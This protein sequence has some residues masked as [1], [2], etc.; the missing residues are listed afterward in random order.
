M[1]KNSVWSRFLILLLGVVCGSFSVIF[2]RLATVPSMVLVAYRMCFASLFLVP[3]IAA[4]RGEYRKLSR[5][6]F[7]LPVFGGVSLGLHFAMFFQ[8]VRITSVAAASVLCNTQ[9][10]F[11]AA[12]SILIFRTRYGLKCYLAMAGAL[13]G[14]CLISLGGA[15][16]GTGSMI[17]NL[18]AAGSA[19]ALAVY[20]MVSS[21]CRQRMDTVLYTTITY[22]ASALTAI[23]ISLCSGL[24]LLGGGWMDAFAALG[25]AVFCTFLGHSL[26]SYSLKTFSPALVSTVQLLDSV[27]C[28]LWGVWFFGE[29][30]TG[31]VLFGG[32]VATVSVVIFCYLERNA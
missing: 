7:L 30:P 10:L 32:V 22:P 9:V 18:L 4:R 1:K 6:M 21:R 3:Q 20:T 14:A 25:M 5:R 26:F 24:D 11:V 27:F 2:S 15:S 28:V 13:I 29:I 8:A 23:I 19:A 31:M 17:G 12:F 16:D